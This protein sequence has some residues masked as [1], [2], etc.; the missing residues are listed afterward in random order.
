M[1]CASNQWS[2]ATPG[3]LTAWF[4][5]RRRVGLGERRQFDEPDPGVPVFVAGGFAEGGSRGNH[6]HRLSRGA[7]GIYVG[8]RFALCEESGFLK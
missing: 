4:G 2:S 7:H 3:N 5:S 8:S 1:P 6:L